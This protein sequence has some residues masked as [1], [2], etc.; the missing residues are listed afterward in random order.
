MSAISDLYQE[1]II[2]HSRSPKN[3]GGLSNKSHTA[4]GNNPLCGDIIDVDLFIN[5]DCI[6]NVSFRGDG[7]AISKASASLMTE[8]IKGRSL[9]DIKILFDFFHGMLVNDQVPSAELKKLLV[10]EGVKQ[11]PMRVKCATL[12]WHTLMAAIEQQQNVTTE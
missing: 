10:F 9:K 11:F 1:I 4:H 8:S 6:E 3:F 5:N 2:D 7:C 12:C